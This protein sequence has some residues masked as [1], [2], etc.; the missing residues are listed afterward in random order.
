MAH[1]EREHHRPRARD[2]RLTMDLK[3]TGRL[4]PG[5]RYTT[6]REL[7]YWMEKEAQFDLSR[8][9]KSEGKKTIHDL[10][11]ELLTG[12]STLMV[13]DNRVLRVVHVAKIKI[14]KPSDALTRGQSF[15]VSDHAKDDGDTAANRRKVSIAAAKR[16]RGDRQVLTETYQLKPRKGKEDRMK[17]RFAIMAEKFD[18]TTE[19]GRKAAVRGI[20]EELG[21]QHACTLLK[22]T[23][24]QR[25]TADEEELVKEA[26]GRERFIESPHVGMKAGGIIDIAGGWCPRKHLKLTDMQ[27]PR[28]EENK[29]QSYPG[30]NGLY[31]LYEFSAE[32][33]GLRLEKKSRTK[34]YK[35]G[36]GTPKL[37][38]DP[39]VT[40]QW[41]WRWQSELDKVGS[42]FAVKMRVKHDMLHREGRVLEPDDAAED[43][44]TACEKGDLDAVKMLLKRV[45]NL[46]KKDAQ[47]KRDCVTE[48]VSRYMKLARKKPDVKKGKQSSE[49]RNA[50]CI[51]KMLL[52][53]IQKKGY[54]L[55]THEPKMPQWQYVLTPSQYSP[56]PCPCSR[57]FFALAL[58]PEE[59]PRGNTRKPVRD[60][61]Q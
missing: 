58:L 20:V 17:V 7:A 50:K 18:P 19:K 35:H 47:T 36:D 32:I 5:E 55:T 44:I 14:V 37:R 24:G 30:L 1:S 53:H 9:Q 8:W 61:G 22:V 13:R 46:D 11:K 41:E 28:E 52:D 39:R 60:V 49:A 26:G 12:D 2:K 29:S 34:E 15:G 27:L 57:A 31:R 6:E 33:S 16:A 38:N 54:H 40:H 25:L 21:G 48:A 56:F 4:E 43:L 10:Y 45:D 51:V 3:F 42:K 23:T 59:D